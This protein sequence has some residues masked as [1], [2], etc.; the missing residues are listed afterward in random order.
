[1]LVLDFAAKYGFEATVAKPGL[2]MAGTLT[3][4]LFG[5]VLRTTGV[6]PSVRVEEVAAAMLQQVVNG[7]EKDPLT[8]ADL[9][10]IGHAALERQK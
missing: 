1:M 8:N 9:V 6:V 5:A 3:G 10:R 2:I 7:F 4:S